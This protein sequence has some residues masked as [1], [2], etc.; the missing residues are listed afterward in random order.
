MEENRVYSEWKLYIVLRENEKNTT[1]STI[2]KHNTY[3]H[4]LKHKDDKF[5]LLED[6]SRKD[7]LE[8]LRDRK[9]N[10][11]VFSITGQS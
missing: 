9:T 2:K 11:I 5:Y 4:Y 1:I 7:A 6:E 10:Q 8:K 3:L